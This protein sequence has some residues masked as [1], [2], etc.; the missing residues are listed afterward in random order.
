MPVPGAEPSPDA[1]V[2][3]LHNSYFDAKLADT[4]KLT[5]VRAG[6]LAARGVE[7][8]DYDAVGNLLKKSNRMGLTLT[9]AYDVRDQVQNNQQY[10]FPLTFYNLKCLLSVVG[11]KHFE[12]EFF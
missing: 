7:D 10:F 5:Q 11:R 12:T 1:G 3:T 2:A 9:F 6:W 4:M 8:F